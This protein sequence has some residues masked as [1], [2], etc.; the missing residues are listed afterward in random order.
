MLFNLLIYNNC[1]KDT[2]ECTNQV[3]STYAQ[4]LNTPGSYTCECG[5]GFKGDGITC[6]GNSFSN[7]RFLLFL[8]F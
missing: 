3:C 4:C 6:N 8:F 7:F 2:N 1:N 5:T